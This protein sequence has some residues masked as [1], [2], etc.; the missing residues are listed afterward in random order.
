[1]SAGCVVQKLWM[2]LKLVP[3]S[4]RCLLA[5]PTLRQHHSDPQGQRFQIC[6]SSHHLLSCVCVYNLSPPLP[7][8]VTHNCIWGSQITLCCYLPQDPFLP[9]LFPLLHLPLLPSKFCIL[10]FP[11]VTF[12]SSRTW[13]AA[14]FGNNIFQLGTKFL[15][16]IFAPAC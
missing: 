8:M 1:M 3:L 13:A 5:F 12:I 11:F 15:F 4:F 7:F 2:N 9:C 6:T 16:W 14:S 10:F